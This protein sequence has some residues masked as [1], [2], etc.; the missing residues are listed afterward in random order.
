MAKN[1]IQRGSTITVVAPAD[2]LS[3]GGVLVGDIFGVAQHDALSGAP[4]EI[5]VDEVWE[6]AKTSAQAWASVGLP[7]YWDASGKVVTTTASTNKLIGVNLAVAANPSDTG[8]V[9]LNGIFAAP[10]AAQMDAGDA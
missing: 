9:R 1:H 6:L 3:G 4:V 7:I 5:K 8:I 2:V 10:S